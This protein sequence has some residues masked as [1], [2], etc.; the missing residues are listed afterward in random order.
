MISLEGP[1]H[2]P[3][4]EWSGNTSLGGDRNVYF[5]TDDRIIRRSLRALIEGGDIAGTHVPTCKALFD[6]LAENEE[7]DVVM[8]A[9]CG[10]RYA[11]IAVA[12]DGRLEISVEI[13]SA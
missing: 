8:Y 4:Y 13:H 7:W 5:Q 3:G 2:C 9:H 10:G 12:H 6:A 1:L 11:D